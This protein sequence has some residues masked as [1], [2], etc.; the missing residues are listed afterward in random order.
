MKFRHLAA[1][2]LV[3]SASAAVSAQD[4]TSPAAMLQQFEAAARVSDARF[5][6]FSAPRGAAFFAAKHGR[7]LS[8]ASCHQVDPRAVGRHASTGREIAPL[9]PNA[10]AQR[11]TDPAK[12]AKWFKRNCND[13]LGRECTP[14]EKG[15]LLAWLLGRVS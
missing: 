15:D 4:K 10:N 9:A 1:V 12:T 14:V 7:D 8:C 5:N 13:V 6:G 2:A 11:F 3:A